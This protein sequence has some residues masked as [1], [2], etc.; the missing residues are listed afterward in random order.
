MTIRTKFTL[1]KVDANFPKGRFTYIKFI[2]R[3]FQNN[4]RLTLFYAAI[5]TSQPTYLKEK[6]A[7]PVILGETDQYE[8]QSKDILNSILEEELSHSDSEA[9]IEELRAGEVFY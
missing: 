2:T 8:D 6:T 9:L 3:N 1:N 5:Q 7:F 4:V